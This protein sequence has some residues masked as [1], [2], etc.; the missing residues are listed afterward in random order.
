MS[1]VMIFAVSIATFFMTIAGGLL[2]IRLKDRLHLIL[3]FSAGAVVGVAFFDLLPEA[4]T[5]GGASYPPQT[6]LALAALGF[7][8]YLALDRYI[9]HHSHHEEGHAGHTHRGV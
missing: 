5:L 2:A 1:A 7:A 3:G 9:L 8:L 6:I 4:I